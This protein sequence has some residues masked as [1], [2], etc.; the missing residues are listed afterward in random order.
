MDQISQACFCDILLKY[1]HAH[2]FIVYGYSC[3][4]TVELS[5]Y[6]KDRNY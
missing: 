6:S 5:S 2:V 4:L 3:V 1:N